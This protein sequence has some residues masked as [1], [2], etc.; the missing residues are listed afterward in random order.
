M[1]VEADAGAAVRPRVGVAAPVYRLSWRLRARL[2]RREAHQASPVE[3][4]DRRAAAGGAAATSRHREAD[5]EGPLVEGE[6]G[7]PVGRQQ[8]RSARAH[9][10]AR[11]VRRQRHGSPGRVVHHKRRDPEA[12][13]GRCAEHLHAPRR[14]AGGAPIVRERRDVELYRR[15]RAKL[16]LP[17]KR[18]D[19]LLVEA[20]APGLH[21]ELGRLGCGGRA[22]RRAEAGVD[23]TAGAELA[24]VEGLAGHREAEH[25]RVA[26]PHGGERG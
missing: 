11:A 19:T 3:R 2:V 10:V 17:Q 16:R 8:V 14:R 1:R 9:H 12:V 20:H 13:P 15:V 4:H 21:L 7:G 24:G 23:L 26:L 22:Q 5:A 18:L 25:G 6:L